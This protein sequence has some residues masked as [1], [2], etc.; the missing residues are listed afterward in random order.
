LRC[1][2]LTYNVILS[3]CTDELAWRKHCFEEFKRMI[4]SAERKEEES[5]KIQCLKIESHFNNIFRIIDNNT[6]ILECSEMNFIK[7]ALGNSSENLL[8][9]GFTY[10]ENNK[11]PIAN[12]K[13]LCA[14]QTLQVAVTIWK[15]INSFI[16]Q[17]TL[18]DITPQQFC[19]Q[20]LRVANATD[21]QKLF[22]KYNS[23]GYNISIDDILALTFCIKN[24][25]D[26]HS[27]YNT[28]SQKYKVGSGHF[29]LRIPTN[30]KQDALIEIYKNRLLQYF[31]INNNNKI[32]KRRTSTT[33]H[34][35]NIK[36][37][38]TDIIIPTTDATQTNRIID[39]IVYHMSC[40]SLNSKF[41]SYLNIHS[42]KLRDHQVILYY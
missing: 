9:S 25:N 6:K 14:Q 19:E 36:K 27:I 17:A 12:S 10:I 24:A 8:R 30:I 29:L 37:P 2:F 3:T 21:L 22:D 32:R 35:I 26:F 39:L 18:N 33:N 41:H 7:S 1:F 42:N 16:F 31:G 28:S 20:L 40:K 23:K 15:S 38:K 4:C 34:A 11:D 5:F 13:C